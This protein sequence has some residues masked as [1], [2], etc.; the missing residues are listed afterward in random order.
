MKTINAILLL[1][2]ATFAISCSKDEEI[3]NPSQPQQNIPV[4]NGGFENWTNN[5]P[6]NWTTNSCPPCMAPY[7]TYIVRQ[8]TVAYQGQFAAKFIYNNTYAAW[9]Q[10][11]FA[12]TTHPQY[13][14]AY[15]K[16]NLVTT[17]S[18]LI[19][20]KVFNNNVEVDSG[21]WYGTTSISNYTQLNVPIS[22]NATQAD[23]VNIYIEGGHRGSLTWTNTEFWVDAVELR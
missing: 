13:L 20:V 16:C 6:D 19:R 12:V 1:C 8:D 2:I 3:P 11:G 17:D 21:E 9:A 14:S 4:A 18:V 23:S 22:Q 15:V 5:L 10:N 7:E